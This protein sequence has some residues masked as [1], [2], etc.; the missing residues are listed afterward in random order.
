[1]K[2]KYKITEIQVDR[3]K[4]ILSLFADINLPPSFCIYI[5]GT[6]KQTKQMYEGFE[7]Y[8]NVEVVWYDFILGGVLKILRFFVAGY[9]GLLKIND[10]KI[11]PKIFNRVAES[12]MAGIYLIN[13]NIENEFI[14]AVK[15][16]KGN[17]FEINEVIV[18]N[19]NDYAIYIIDNDSLEFETGI[20]EIVKIGD[21]SFFK[22]AYDSVS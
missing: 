15:D 14:Q 21:E 13:E 4:Y 9:A 5:Y 8:Q 19:T 17:L 6:G 10:P 2:R 16:K 20:C 7:T 22:T 11:I 12:S 1:M 18:S 3:Y